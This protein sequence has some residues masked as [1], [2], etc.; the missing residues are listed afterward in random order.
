MLLK[1]ETGNNVIF[2]DSREGGITVLHVAKMDGPEV[3]S[4]NNPEYEDPGK[5]HGNQRNASLASNP[6][7]SLAKPNIREGELNVLHEAK[8]DRPEKDSTD[9]PEYEDPVK[10]HGNQ[11]NALTSN[12]VYS[13][14]KPLPDYELLSEASTVTSGETVAM[15]AGSIKTSG[16]EELG[17]VSGTPSQK[18]YEFVDAIQEGPHEYE[19]VSEIAKSK[20]KKRTP[21]EGL[22]KG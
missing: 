22:I 2:S 21:Y 8:M 11:R 18:G 4:I 19:M 5:S 7:Y 6:V 17:T 15:E 1:I 13:L 12:P 14:A 9:I 3:D 16:Y 20:E 10:G